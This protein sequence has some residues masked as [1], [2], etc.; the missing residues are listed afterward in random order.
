MMTVVSLKMGLQT[1][2]ISFLKRK[3][4]LRA[5]MRVKMNVGKVRQYA[6][7]KKRGAHFPPPVVFC[8]HE[9][10]YWVGDGFHRIEADVM[11]KEKE[12][13]VDVRKG[14]LKEAIM[15]NL[16]ANR[17]SQGLPFRQG[18]I[19]KAV[20]Y[21]LLSPMFKEYTRTQ[22]AEIVGCTSGMVSRVAI[23]RLGFRKHPKMGRKK[24]PTTAKKVVEGL[25][26]GKSHKEV[27]EELGLSERTTYRREKDAGYMKCPHCNGTGLVK[28]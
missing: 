20:K 10:V 23:D 19:T 28:M 13:A 22:I 24:D 3:D 15:W 9:E 2:P 6:D 8:N 17:E 27:A 11:N 7:E 12:I 5:E 21:M 4:W 16:R 25:M 26:A 14:G 1:L 18:D